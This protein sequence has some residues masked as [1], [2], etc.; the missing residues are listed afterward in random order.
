M[1]ADDLRAR[2]RDG[3]DGL[4]I[5]LPTF[6]TLEAASAV[7]D[8][9]VV[10]LEHSASG[11]AEALDL[12]QHARALGFPALVRLPQVDAGR[13]N[14]ALEAG[15]VGV[16]LS[17]VQRVEDVVAARTALQF[18]PEG[19]R[20]VSTAHA[21]AGFGA[22]PLRDYVEQSE[23]PLLVA[24][25]EDVETESPLTEIFGAGV[26]VAF[27][28][29]ADLSV[30]AGFDT[31]TVSARIEEVASA[32][33]DVGIAFGG[34]GLEHQAARYRMSCSD[35]SL[36]VSGLEAQRRRGPL[37]AQATNWSAL[38]S[39]VVRPGVSRRGFGTDKCLLIMNSCEPGMELRPHS[40]PFEQI[41]LITS[42]RGR[43]HVG[44]TPH[45]VGPGSVLLIPAGV[46][47]FMETVDETV[48]NLD[49]FAPPRADYDHLVAWMRESDGAGGD[50]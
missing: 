39:E 46:T 5:K 41:A 7:F 34:F 48:E 24:Q 16:Q 13:I 37:R 45:E 21:G 10:D 49:V 17:G 29:T 44:D 31:E 35:I 4:F 50:S 30:D 26:D 27:V 6:E 42:G 11:E 9:G 2:L 3:L 23:R 12:L 18:P 36:F 28:G 40:H 38:P 22:T 20:S 43:Y 33:A 8:F 14:R 1:T 25:I 15:A 19:R 32:A 47:H